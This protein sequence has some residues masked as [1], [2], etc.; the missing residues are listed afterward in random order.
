MRKDDVGIAKNYL[1]E[2]E[3]Q[4]LNCIVNIYI[5]YAELQ[6]L[7]RKPMTMR[8][9]IAKLDEFLKASGRPLLEHAGAVSADD[10]RLKAERE[11]EQYRQLLDAQPRRIDT[12]FKKAAK[13]LKKLPKPRKPRENK[14]RAE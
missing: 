14:R 1:I 7:E 3:L 13:E 4:V 12:D 8:D 9:W 2:S 5:E 11:Y 6:A 10:A